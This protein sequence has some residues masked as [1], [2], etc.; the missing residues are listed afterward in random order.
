MVFERYCGEDGSPSTRTVRE[1]TRARHAVAVCTLEGNG[2]RRCNHPAMAA[3][4]MTPANLTAYAM[5]RF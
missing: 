1:V 4:Q 5:S 3:G 2:V